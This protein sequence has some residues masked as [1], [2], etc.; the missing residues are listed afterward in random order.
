MHI[1]I[2]LIWLLCIYTM[3][4]LKPVYSFG[5]NPQPNY[6]PWPGITST[7]FSMYQRMLQLMEPT[8]QGSI[9]SWLILQCSKSSKCFLVKERWGFRTRIFSWGLLVSFSVVVKNHFWSSLSLTILV[10]DGWLMFG[11]KNPLKD[12]NMIYFK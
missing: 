1:Y 11:K 12:F 2:I 9:Y 4:D 8:R 3:K 5:L 6:V 10:E 7:T